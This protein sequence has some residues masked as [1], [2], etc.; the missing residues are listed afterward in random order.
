[1]QHKS[2]RLEYEPCSELLRISAKQL[3]SSCSEIENYLFLHRKLHQEAS[4][5]DPLREAQ[6]RLEAEGALGAQ[7]AMRNRKRG[8]WKSICRIQVQSPAGSSK[9]LCPWPDPPI[10]LLLI[11]MSVGADPADSG[12]LGNGPGVEP[13]HYFD[14]TGFEPHTPEPYRG[15]SPIRKRPPP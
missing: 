8:W 11:M 9:L 7:G 12:V 6:E 3:F 14:Q 1:M 5:V 13:R 10:L 4:P 2:I 15:T